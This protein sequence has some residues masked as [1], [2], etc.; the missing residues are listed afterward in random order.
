MRSGVQDQPDQHGETPFLLKIQ[1]LASC[2]DAFRRLRQK[3]RLNPEGRGCSEPRSCHC[4]PAW[5]TEQD[6]NS[7]KERWCFALVAQAELQRCDLTT[8]QPLPPGFKRFSLP[9]PPDRDGVSP[10]WSAGFE[11]LTSGD[12]P[13]LAS[14]SAGIAGVS[15]YTQPGFVTMTEP[16]SAQAAVQGSHLDSLQPLSP[17]FKRFFCLSLL[18]AGTGSH[19]YAQLISFVF[20][21]L[22]LSPRLECNGLITAHCS[23]S[24]LGSSDPLAS[25]SRAAATTDLYPEVEL[26]KILFFEWSLALSP[27]LE[28]SGTHDLGSL[29]P[30]PP[31]FKRFSC[32]SLLS[33]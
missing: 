11:C 4:T 16:H 32:L 29:P 23:F 13:T 21:T 28:C 22:V 14:Q 33:T 5:V 25:A 18:V 7:K 1:K 24:L 8:P 26:K 15:H 27:R 20:L 2:G 3:N 12:P 19:H 30:P 10:C 9:Q 17:R 31:G 6:S